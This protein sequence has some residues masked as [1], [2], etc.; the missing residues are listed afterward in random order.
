MLEAPGK[1]SLL[2]CVL[3]VRCHPRQSLCSRGCGE[4]PRQPSMDVCSR[5]GELR[6]G[7][8]GVGGPGC[9]MRHRTARPGPCHRHQTT[10]GLSGPQE[11]ISRA[12][13]PAIAYRRPL[14]PCRAEAGG[15]DAPSSELHLGTEWVVCP[16][17]TLGCLHAASR[18]GR[19]ALSRTCPKLTFRPEPSWETTREQAGPM[20]RRRCRRENP[21]L[22]SD[23]GTIT[24]FGRQRPTSGVTAD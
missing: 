24:R 21:C 16:Q 10:G 5:T 12:H 14:C 8:R 9:G 23:G 6:R 19:G 3:Q 4:D 15:R 7:L 20:R 1:T 2:F 17:D 22:R 11:R 13:L 18:Q